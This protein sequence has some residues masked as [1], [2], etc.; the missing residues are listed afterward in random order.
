MTNEAGLMAS[1]VSVSVGLPDE[2]FTWG[3]F[4]EKFTAEG[5]DEESV[6]IGDEFRVGGARLVVTEPRMPASNSG[7]DSTVRTW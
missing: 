3:N 5:V 1:L 2:D 7:F 4:G 6:C